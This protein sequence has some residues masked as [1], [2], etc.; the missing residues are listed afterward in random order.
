[1]TLQIPMHFLNCI[2]GSDY[3]V[4]S[5]A[6]GELERM[7]LGWPFN[8]LTRTGT[9]P[10]TRPER[11]G[12]GRVRHFKGR[13]FSGRVYWHLEIRVFFGSIPEKVTETRKSFLAR[14]SL[15]CASNFPQLVIIDLFLLK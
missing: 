10:E 9:R 7:V 4:L 1:M 15:F 6:S 14:D 13:V 12:S 11:G 5:G 3:Q 2:L 8:A